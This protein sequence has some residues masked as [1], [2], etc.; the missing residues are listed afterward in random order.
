[1]TGPSVVREAVRNPPDWPQLY[2]Y[3]CRHAAAK[4]HGFG[5]SDGMLIPQPQPYTLHAVL[6]LTDLETPDRDALGLTSHMLNCD[7]TE[8]RF[9]VRPD[10]LKWAMR[11]ASWARAVHLRRADREALETAT[12]G[13]LPAHW[14]VSLVPLWAVTR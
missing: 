11:Y 13:L 14:F 7:R 5:R 3:T 2:H 9:A 12:P 4:I 1:M 8:V 10:D 6:W